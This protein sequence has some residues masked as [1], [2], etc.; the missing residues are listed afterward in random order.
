MWYLLQL[1]NIPFSI[2]VLASVGTKSFLSGLGFFKIFQSFFWSFRVFCSPKWP[3]RFFFS[4]LIEK[5]NFSLENII[6]LYNFSCSKTCQRYIILQVILTG[7]SYIIWM[8]TNCFH[9]SHVQ[10]LCCI[11]FLCQL[12]LMLCLSR[13]SIK[14][15]IPEKWS[16]ITIEKFPNFLVT[17]V[18]SPVINT[19]G[20]L[21][22]SIISVKIVN[23]ISCRKDNTSLWF[24]NGFF[25]GF[26]KVS[27][28][29]R[30]SGKEIL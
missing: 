26:R 11:Y 20:F 5:D 1:H 22:T 27:I 7:S 3:I 23:V 25:F 21:Q 13:F 24:L 8:W 29:L 28:F 19:G 16:S 12:F 10:S 14:H 9:L 30:N 17:A 2:I 15:F 18:P 6:H 4:I